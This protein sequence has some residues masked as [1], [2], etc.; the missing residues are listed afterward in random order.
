VEGS[1]ALQR[2]CR[3]KKRGLLEGLALARLSGVTTKRGSADWKI[4][5]GGGR[6]RFFFLPSRGAFT[7]TF[8]FVASRD[9]PLSLALGLV[10]NL[11]L[12]S[13][14]LPRST[15]FDA[16]SPLTLS[17]SGLQ[18]AKKQRQAHIFFS[19]LRQS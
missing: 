4:R 14:F 11:S 7:S 15:R 3:L 13:F 6:R 5:G 2:Q 17:E 10:R 8:F 1:R 19:L 16:F 12:F 9:D 18:G